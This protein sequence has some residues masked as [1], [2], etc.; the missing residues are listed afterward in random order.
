[1]A[2]DPAPTQNRR[3]EAPTANGV[4]TKYYYCWFTKHLVPKKKH[5]HYPSLKTQELT[6]LNVQS[7]NSNFQK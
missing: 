4:D 2:L 7:S 6:I 3:S 5:P 1:M